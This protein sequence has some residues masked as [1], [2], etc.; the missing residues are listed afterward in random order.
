MSVF[1]QSLGYRRVNSAL[2]ALDHWLQCGAGN[3][4]LLRRVQQV[5]GR[6]QEVGDRAG[7]RFG[8]FECDATKLL[9]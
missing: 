8:A 6:A 7:Q 5:Y 3:P 4:K 9:V 2:R 1:V